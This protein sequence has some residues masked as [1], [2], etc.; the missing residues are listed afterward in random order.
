MTIQFSTALQ[1]QSFVLSLTCSP[2]LYDV[3]F[4][5]KKTIIEFADEQAVKRS[6]EQAIPTQSTAKKRT[7]HQRH[8]P[9]AKVLHRNT[10]LMEPV[11]KDMVRCA[12]VIGQVDNK[13]I[14][15]VAGNRILA[16]DQHAVSERIRFEELQARLFEEGIARQECSMKIDLSAD[17]LALAVKKEAFLERWGWK[18]RIDGESVELL[19][20]PLLFGKLF[21]LED[22][23]E[24]LKSEDEMIPPCFRRQ[25][26]SRACRTAIMFGD[27]IEHEEC[28]DL[29]LRLS[30][31]VYPFQCAH[32]RPNVFQICF[33]NH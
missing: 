29:L 24:C 14:F 28:C 5:P 20:V 25:L 22:F 15:A 11:T 13:Y 33:V 32:G 26:A 18:V 21:D 10:E 23:A 16:F 1:K 4:D 6:L 19:S 30:R 31:C 17:D 8:V 2:A 3:T 7:L 12:T 9:A 27:K